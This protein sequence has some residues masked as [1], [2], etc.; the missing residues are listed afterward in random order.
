MG[1]LKICNL[2]MGVPAFF[3]RKLR[4][5]DK[6]WYFWVHDKIMQRLTTHLQ[7]R[8]IAPNWASKL[9][10]KVA[11][12]L[13]KTTRICCPDKVRDRI[14]PSEAKIKILYVKPILYMNLL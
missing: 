7:V 1:S 5:Y 4:K 6:K 14:T 12:Q 2:Y 8:K 10:V 11:L 9:C 13:C 3:L